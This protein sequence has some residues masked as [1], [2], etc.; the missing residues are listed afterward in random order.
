MKHTLT[1]T[2][3]ADILGVHRQ[4]VA[5]YVDRGILSRS[6]ANKKA[7]T[8]ESVEN[9][10]KQHHDFVLIAREVKELQ[11]RLQEEKAE[12]AEARSNV[13]SK[14]EFH[15]AKGITHQ[16]IGYICDALLVYLDAFGEKLTSREKHIIKA[17]FAH[18]DLTVLGEDL[19]LTVNRVREIFQKVLRRLA[20][21]TRFAE[22]KQEHAAM[23]ELICVKDEQIAALRARVEELKHQLHVEEIMAGNDESYVSVPK[24]WMK[25][26]NEIGLS[27]RAYNCLRA[28]GL[29]F[30][31]E[32]AFLSLK[33]MMRWRNL[34]RKSLN[35]IDLVKGKL[36]MAYDTITDVTKFAEYRKN[37]ERVAVPFVI[38]ENKRRNIQ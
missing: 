30:A 4:S 19:G 5:N 34:G 23:K 29:E 22:I 13:K 3:A 36:G 38:L 26:I 2:E 31:Y 16:N 15:K 1:Y 17:V 24:E 10:M 12:L 7:V 9:L 11:E 18:T 14:I 25:K 32:L 37:A 33:D 8:R 35:E 27:V 28:G 6:T 20:Y 21:S